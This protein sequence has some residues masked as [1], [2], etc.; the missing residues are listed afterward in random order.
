MRPEPAEAE[1]Y[2]LSCCLCRLLEAVIWNLPSCSS[3]PLCCCGRTS[4]S[5]SGSLRPPQPLGVGKGRRQ[6]AK[7]PA[8][9]AQLTGPRRTSYDTEREGSLQTMHS[10]PTSPQTEW[11]THTSRGNRHRNTSVCCSYSRSLGLQSL[12]IV[13][14]Q[15]NQFIHLFCRARRKWRLAFPIKTV[16]FGTQQRLR[17]ETQHIC[18]LFKKY[19]QLKVL[20]LRLPG[21][22]PVVSSS[23]S[24]VTLFTY[25]KLTL[26]LM[27]RWFKLIWHL[28]RNT[29]GI[30][31]KLLPPLICALLHSQTCP[32]ILPACPLGRVM[33]IPRQPFTA[34]LTN[35]PPPT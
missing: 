7:R 3:G 35:Q 34:K 19:W 33:T 21:N 13:R 11:E 32:C 25:R 9:R 15:C 17:N 16:F 30:N 20:P 26:T 31:L 5:P 28:R 27:L 10:P 23:K 6:Q 29:N 18:S 24:R 1:S 4:P 22:T 8:G 2:A 14:D 12:V